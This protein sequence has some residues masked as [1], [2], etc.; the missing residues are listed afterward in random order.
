MM[1]WK[2]KILDI[3]VILGFIFFAFITIVTYGYEGGVVFSLGVMC[4]MGLLAVIIS[5]VRNK[6]GEFPIRGDK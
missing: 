6:Y 3:G 5:I 4:G 2:E 1:N